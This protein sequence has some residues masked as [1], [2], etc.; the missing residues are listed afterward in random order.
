M[1]QALRTLHGDPNLGV[2]TVPEQPTLGK[3]RVLSM[4][5]FKPKIICHLW[6]P[7]LL[8]FVMTN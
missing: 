2:L 1:A 3:F 7:H 5:G 6:G 4:A 8:V